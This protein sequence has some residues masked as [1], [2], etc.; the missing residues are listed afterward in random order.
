[1][2][3][4]TLSLGT[5]SLG[6]TV[7]FRRTC[8]SPFRLPLLVRTLLRCDLAPLPLARAQRGPLALVRRYSRRYCRAPAARYSPAAAA[9]AVVAV[10]GGLQAEGGPAAGSGIGSG[11][12]AAP[13]VRAL[14]A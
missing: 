4:S 5:L 12:D 11:H 13:L 6:S 7:A 14:G 2:P 1:M 3:A 9:V 10:V 8:S